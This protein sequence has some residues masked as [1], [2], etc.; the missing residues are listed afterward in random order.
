MNLL[1]DSHTLLWALHDPERLV[2]SARAAIS[3]PRRAVYFSAA[4]AWELEIK[5]A[6]GKLVLPEHWLAAATSTGFLELAV[7]AS[8]AQ[9]S[10]RLPWHHHDP[11]DR[12]L[13]AQALTYGLQLATR[14]PLIAA[15]EVP[16]LLV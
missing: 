4:S 1:L 2:P 8:D 12:V 15:Y 7:T 14:D 16:R 10:A 9:R 13:I 3:D 5:A 11:F 6:K